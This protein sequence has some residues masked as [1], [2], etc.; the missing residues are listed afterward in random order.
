[1]DRREWDWQKTEQPEAAEAL[2]SQVQR[3]QRAL[4]DQQL[5]TVLNEFDGQLMKLDAGKRRIKYAKMMQ[6]PFT[7]FR[8]SA[9]LFYSDA[10]REWMPYHTKAERPTWIQGDLHFENF[11]A[12]RNEGGQLVYDVNDFDE[13]YLGSYLYDV[14]RMSVSV[15][16]VCR[17]KGFEEG[18]RLALGEAYLRAYYDQIRR[19][20]KGKDDP[21]SY[22]MDEERASGPIR[23]LLKKLKKRESNHY[24]EKV[25]AHMRGT[26]RFEASEDIVPAS[27]E[28]RE[29]ILAVWPSYAE[30]LAEQ[31]RERVGVK[32][33]AVKHGS[34][35]ASIGLDRY[36]ILAEG[37]SGEQ[38]PADIVLEM[39]EVRVPVPAY[40]LPR[41][42]RFWA[43]FGHQGKRVIATQ[44]AMH[45]EADPYLGYLTL[46]GRE[47]Y[48]RERSP[49]K[50]R[51]KLDAISDAAEMTAVL[52]G[53]GRL[54]A[55]MHAR[56]DADVEQGVLAY[57][58]EAEILAAMGDDEEAFCAF[59]AGWAN[60][61]A[62][63]VEQDYELFQSWAKRRRKG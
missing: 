39:K 24:L 8:G 14:L 53:M 7:F 62:E 61:Y 13:G 44:R 51:L 42:E 3:T 22:N 56:A 41:N 45:H 26:R 35:T 40:F 21:A 15:S 11:G 36:Y 27:A 30:G 49:Y 18:Q 31:L 60:G 20:A 55:K 12:F 59:V 5:R 52:E 9:Y 34:G 4:R 17:M 32:D 54:T 19:F 16:L 23:R 33:I 63:Q 48:I 43:A 57:H 58:S 28:E 1:M 10:A 6:S 2:T 29:A 46:D 37:G 38:E 25:T 47:Y 50:K